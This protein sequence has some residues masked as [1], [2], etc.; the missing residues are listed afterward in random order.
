M[1]IRILLT[2]VACFAIVGCVPAYTLVAS[3][4]VAVG[5]LQLVTPNNLNQAPPVQAP[6]LRKDSVLFTNDG[7]DLDR[8]IVIPGVA[9]GETLIVAPARSDVALPT[10]RAGMLPNE[11]EEMAESTFVKLFGEGNVVVATDGLRP[12]TFGDQ[13]G[14]MFD[15]TATIADAPK[16][17]G[18]VGAFIANDRLYMVIYLAATPYY[19][20]KHKESAA[21]IIKSA[22]LAVVG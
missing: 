19:F 21:S 15:I 13:R 1:N 16:Q 12:Q 20:D 10:F 17:N 5:N 11:I 14:F 22:R 3:G 2:T 4:P 18:M 7:P 8:I 9:D 6:M